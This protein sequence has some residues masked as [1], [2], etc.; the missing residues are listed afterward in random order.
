MLGDYPLS[1]TF[2]RDGRLLVL[3]NE[4]EIKIR[5]AAT[6]RLRKTLSDATGDVHPNDRSLVT[7]SK[8]GVREWDLM[9]DQGVIRKYELPEFDQ[10]QES[11]HINTE[12]NADRSRIV[13]YGWRAKAFVVWSTGDCPQLVNRIRI[14]P[15][16]RIRTYSL[17]CDRDQIAALLTPGGMETIAY[18][19][20][21]ISL[22]DG[23]RTVV[24]YWKIDTGE[25]I[26]SLQITTDESLGAVFSKKNT[27]LVTKHEIKICVWNLDGDRA[28]LETTIHVGGRASDVT[29]SGDIIA[30]GCDDFA[31]RFYD[32]HTGAKLAVHRGHSDYITSLG[33][34]HQGGR[35]VSQSLSGST[36][37]WDTTKEALIAN[38]PSAPDDCYFTRIKFSS[39]GK[40]IAAIAW[41]DPRV[42]VWDGETGEFVTALVGHAVSVAAFAF[43]ADHSVLASVSEDGVVL[44]WDMR[45]EV[46]HPRTLSQSQSTKSLKPVDMTFNTDSNLLAIVYKESWSFVVTIYDV[47]VGVELF[48]SKPNSG[49]PPHFIRFSPGEPLVRLRHVALGRQIRLWDHAA[50]TVEKHAYDDNVYSTWI[51]P[52]DIDRNCILSSRTRKRLFWLPEYRSRDDSDGMDVHGDRLAIGSRFGTLTLLD[53][54]RLQDV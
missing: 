9:G 13:R 15:A 39:N 37:V 2:S 32:A 54:S 50:G 38:S 42:I 6:G 29:R 51:L 19:P 12:Y 11:N 35:F 28:T 22:Y 1:V 31:I 44:L 52:F 45:Q 21:S 49:D 27:M 41:R 43:S 14:D 3:C 20:W 33:F 7:V 40:Y 48:Q 26:K 36:H 47:L 24:K 30:V 46:K 5:D 16:M 34:S 25:E 8:D 10:D 17:D 4:N 53:M 23:E 18:M